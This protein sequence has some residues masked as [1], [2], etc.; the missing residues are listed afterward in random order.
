MTVYGGWDDRPDESA[1]AVRIN[2]V[3][4]IT[5][6]LN[7]SDA[8]GPEPVKIPGSGHNAVVEFAAG[9]EDITVTDLRIRVVRR[10]A[11]KPD[12]TGRVLAPE[13]GL[14][15]SADAAEDFRERR[16]KYQPLE[17]PDLEVHLDADPPRLR[18]AL[19]G[20]EAFRF[21]LVVP[22]AGHGRIVL[23]PLTDDPKAVHWEVTPVFSAGGAPIARATWP[24][25]VTAS[26][27][28]VRTGRF[29]KQRPLKPHEVAPHW[30]AGQG[31]TGAAKRDPKLQVFGHGSPDSMRGYGVPNPSPGENQTRWL[32]YEADVPPS[33]P[34][35]ADRVKHVPFI[36]PGKLGMDIIRT[37]IPDCFSGPDQN[38]WLYASRGLESLGQREVVTMVTDPDDHGPTAFAFERFEDLVGSAVRGKPVEPSSIYRLKESVTVDADARVRGGIYTEIHN[39]WL[40]ELVG[41]LDYLRAPLVNIPL[42]GDEVAIAA[43]YGKL[44]VLSHLCRH[45]SAFPF[46]EWL[47]P[48]RDPVL[49][50]DGYAE[51]TLLTD[52]PRPHARGIYAH[53]VGER[54]EVSM[55]AETA[56]RLATGRA[57]QGFSMLLDLPPRIDGLLA[58]NPGHASA[59][60]GGPFA[61]RRGAESHTRLTANALIFEGNMPLTGANVRE[62]FILVNF[63]AHDWR[64][65]LDSL[66][67]GRPYT[68]RMHNPPLNQFSVE[69]REGPEG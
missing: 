60:A 5:V 27:G 46:P 2:C 47:R 29:G 28:M 20:V 61:A 33:R 14:I 7:P 64:S 44:R 42:V 25:T 68:C 43:D 45:E 65:L 40:Q 63:T 53:L 55:P 69:I 3:S 12:G 18:P 19:T 66:Q 10:L 32:E 17:T 34:V 51:K 23:T 38:A 52:M 57:A 39:P 24:L 4:H 41:T 67:H 56:D 50:L 16:E 54:I 1:P 8:V 58:W 21:P 6:E 26:T 11:F 48:G 13:R 49:S 15:L 35:V 30:R 36:H 9:S 31:E 37:R 62:D 22:S 59:M